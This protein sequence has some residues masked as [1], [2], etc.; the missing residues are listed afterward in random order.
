MPSRT[1]NAAVRAFIDPLQRLVSALSGDG[2]FV[3][4]PRPPYRQ[5]VVYV[6]SLNNGEGM[7]LGQ[8]GRLYADVRFEILETGA[9]PDRGRRTVYRCAE[10]SYIYRLAVSG[11]DVWAMHWHPNGRSACTRPHI[12]MPPDPKRH[13]V[14]PHHDFEHA[15]AWAIEWGAP[16]RKSPATLWVEAR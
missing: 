7:S 2:R 5:G 6:A 3:V 1:P 9:A 11:S 10:R 4:T 12:H 13:L 14:G 8:A 16:I 15:V